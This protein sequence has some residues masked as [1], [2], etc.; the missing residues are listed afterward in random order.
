MIESLHHLLLSQ[1][2]RKGEG[3]QGV[4]GG[5]LKGSTRACSDEGCDA[6]GGAFCAVALLCEAM[7]HQVRRRKE[8]GINLYS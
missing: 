8:G 2:G 1:G 3:G 4:R 6:A 7:A 5:A